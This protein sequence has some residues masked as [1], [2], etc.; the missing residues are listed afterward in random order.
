MK[1]RTC[2]EGRLKAE[3]VTDYDHYDHQVVFKVFFKCG[4]C[5]TRYYVHIEQDAFQVKHID[6]QDY[7]SL[8]KI[9]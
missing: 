6:P 1:C 4:F 8:K 7:L 9:E 2:Q 3:S 5:N